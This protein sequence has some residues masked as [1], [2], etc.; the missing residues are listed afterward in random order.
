MKKNTLGTS[1]GKVAALALALG[2]GAAALPS[3][4]PADQPAARFHHVHLNVTD[5][6][7]TIKHYVKFFGAVPVK[8][9]EVSDAL[10]T[11][12]SYILL[13]QVAAKA[14]ANAGTSLWHIGWGGVDGPN[15]Y[16]W[17]TEQ[18]MTWDT[19]IVT[20]GK[21]QGYFM[22]AEGPDGELAEIFTGLVDDEASGV[23]LP[24]ILTAPPH[25]RYNH[26]HLLA[27]DI[28]VTRDWYIDHLGALGD[29]TPIPDPGPPPADMAFTDPPQNTFSAIWN[30]AVVVDSVIFNIFVNPKA[31]AFWWRGDLI[32]KLASTD[33][34][35]IDHYA[36]SYPDIEPV[37][38]RMK[39]DGVEIVK[40]IA[41]D[42]ELK[43]KSFFVRGPDGV[44]IEIVEADP[45][46]DASWLHHAHPQDK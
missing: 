3:A 26:V 21:D 46:P 41:W 25:H 44:L 20:V 18:G 19:D 24:E 30:T 39:A 17:L 40:D 33:G 12:Q 13:N 32:P 36:F 2:L 42:D 45:L 31:P 28:N 1:S 11:G 15:E 4:A 10:V 23:K 35:V 29:K 9:R 22:Y 43:M 37:H 7:T 8:F 27:D 14:P 5:P 38:D 6:A 34:R 16:D